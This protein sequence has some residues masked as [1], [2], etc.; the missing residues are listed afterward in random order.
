M[1]GRYNVFSRCIAS[2]LMIQLI[3]GF[4]APHIAHAD[5]LPIPVP[6]VLQPQL[7]FPLKS[8]VDRL[9][10]YTAAYP[11]TDSDNLPDQVERVVGL[12]PQDADS[13]GDG[14]NDGEEIN[15][16]LDPRE[17]DSNF[18]GLNDYFEVREV[19]SLD[20]DNDN[21]P[22]GQDMDNDADG[23]SDG[24]DLNPYAK[25]G[26][27]SAIT[28]RVA[29]DAKPLFIT[30]QV[31]PQ[32]AAHLKQ[33]LKQWDW[34]D[35]TEGSIMDR[36]HSVED[37]TLIPVLQIEADSL[38]N[39]ADLTATGIVI[40][41]TM[42]IVPL[43]PVNERGTTVALSATVPFAAGG[44]TNLTLNC[45]F[46]WNVMC[47]NDV[48]A[49]AEPEKTCV[50]SYPEAFCITG[51]S[52]EESYGT[53]SGLFYHADLNQTVAANLQ[54]VYDFLQT[55]DTRIVD[56]PAI[57]QSKGI[58]VTGVLGEYAHD[59]QALTA[60]ATTTIP[61]ILNTLPAGTRLPLL[62]L[63]ENKTK[64]VDLNDATGSLADETVFSFSFADQPV[65]TAK[66]L[67]TNW[68]DSSGKDALELKD[69]MAEIAELNLEQNAAYVLMSL[70]M[71]WNAG[72][73]TLFGPGVPR[74]DPVDRDFTI[75]PNVVEQLS[76]GALTGLS[77]LYR[78]DIG[79]FALDAY[80]SIKALQGIGWSVSL[81][82]KN[83]GE[84]SK[85]GTFA[86]FRT[87]ISQSCRVKHTIKVLKNFE[88][89]VDGLDAAA[90]I[91]DTGFAIYSVLSIA[92][93][94]LSTM[95]MTR[96]LLRTMVSFYTDGMFF[97]IGMIPYV[98]WIIAGLLAL[99]DVFGNWTT[100]LA[101]WFVNLLSDVDFQPQT[102]VELRSD[103]TVAVDDTDGN[104]LD[105]G[106]RITVRARLFSKI[107]G[108]DPYW[109]DVSRSELYPYIVLSASGG[110]TRQGYLATMS[111]FFMR[112][113]NT[114]TVPIPPVGSMRQL[115][116]DR[117]NFFKSNE[118]ECGAWVEPGIA[119]PNFPVTLRV[120]T[121]DELWYTWSYFVFL[122][123]YWYWMYF[124]DYSVGIATGDNVKMYFDVLPNSIDD[125][126]QWR[127][128][129]PLDADSDGLNDSEELN[130]SKYLYDSDNDGLND[131][132][133]LKL[134]LAPR[135]HDSDRDG[136]SDGMELLYGT[137][138]LNADTDTDGLTDFI[139]IA[140]WVISL[141]YNG[142]ALSIPVSSSPTIPDSDGD[143]LDDKTEYES[144]LNPRSKDTD[145]DGTPDQPRVKNFYL[146]Q[147]PTFSIDIDEL[148]PS[149]LQKLV[150]DI[151]GFVYPQTD[152]AIGPY[153]IPYPRI[154][155][156]MT[157]GVLMWQQQMP[158]YFIEFVVN[159]MRQS[160]YALEFMP[161]FGWCVSRYDVAR[162]RQEWWPLSS[163]QDMRA[164]HAK[165]IYDDG[166][167]H[168]FI[169]M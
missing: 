56:M 138:P 4:Q 2:V 119:M 93:S 123:F 66:T 78:A 100:D 9:L 158:P 7:I 72:E 23:V 1:S 94:D 140:G 86:K 118:Y 29:A 54:S 148:S 33:F 61:D 87:L 12:D 113:L 160:Y 124:D 71:Y 45:R 51:M 115:V 131:D 91:L 106:D 17:P 16:G 152:L 5:P 104:G 13:D 40:D 96:E 105:V 81:A 60:I 95:E 79:R 110:S 116:I 144:N 161:D 108:W 42:L 153:M 163:L 132:Y 120:D 39:A 136:I 139:E 75:V 101:N 129:R 83:L 53:A 43:L 127:S 52:I 74:L 64:S 151:R 82:G 32:N 20:F 133:E 137:N 164:I 169:T 99:S 80:K 18:D 25:T 162:E 84:L 134:G 22:N 34:P 156:Y 36:D 103:P 98:G 10:P 73:Q 21:V 58:T 146:V 3:F 88:K 92:N 50:A 154:S 41:G 14:L 168:L 47:N 26:Q 31:R 67:K 141:P 70:M 102:Q 117:A 165:R 150:V 143:G 59:E 62:A 167:G 149:A 57:F 145:G 89:V 77:L 69:I 130:S 76:E 114:Q 135:Q 63:F 155:A 15:L 111:E 55:Q 97:L 38:P 109:S 166:N 90:L 128:I 85:L 147:H 19:S 44:V 49:G 6:M 126:L 125:F 30:L 142:I 24:I 37:L 107:S 48:E 65:L 68:F 35:D 11:D 28:L 27:Q 112:P 157:D 8:V 121:I 46:V 122:V 159:E